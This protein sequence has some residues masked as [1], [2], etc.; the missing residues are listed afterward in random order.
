MISPDG[1]ETGKQEVVTDVG[2]L[3]SP[4]IYLPCKDKDVNFI[5]QRGL[6]ELLSGFRPSF[7]TNIKQVFGFLLFLT[8]KLLLKSFIQT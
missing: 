2:T 6:T 5:N 7:L 4:F 1:G 8:L 3:F